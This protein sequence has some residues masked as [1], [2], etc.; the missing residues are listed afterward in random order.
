MREK[1]CLEENQEKAVKKGFNILNVHAL[2][3]KRHYNGKPPYQNSIPHTGGISFC[4][5]QH[6]ITYYPIIEDDS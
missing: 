3:E 6:T 1:T 4:K 2:K 5:R